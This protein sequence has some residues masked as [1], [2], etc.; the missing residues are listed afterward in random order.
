MKKCAM[1]FLVSPVLCG[2]VTTQLE[3]HTTNQVASLSDLRYQEVLDN[4]ALMASRNGALP[5]FALTGGGLTSVI[6]SVGIEPKTIWDP[7]GFL[8]QSLTVSG[9]YLPE[10]QWNIEPLVA[11]PQLQ[12]LKY[13]CVWA[14]YGQEA[15]DPL[16]ADY[17]R[18]SE[19]RDVFPAAKDPPALTQYHFDV[20]DRLS[21]LP[22]GWIHC[23]C[24]RDVDRCACYKSHCGDTYVWVNPDGLQAL[25]D[26]ALVVLDIATC[27]PNSLVPQSP[28]ATVEICEGPYNCSSQP[29]DCICSF[30]ELDS[31]GKPLNDPAHAGCAA[32]P[33]LVLTETWGVHQDATTGS[34]LVAGGGFAVCVPFVKSPPRTP[35]AAPTRRAVGKAFSSPSGTRYEPTEL[36]VAPP[37]P[38]S[39]P[40]FRTYGG[41]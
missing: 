3:S 12:A 23:G 32:D 10:L 19:R 39:L 34:Y 6:N 35:T 41:R 15:V 13:A 4:L 17:L 22:N 1:L 21:R 27:D 5:S 11:E 31:S 28:T 37:P 8:Q 7:H 2:C 24:R 38:V 30:A 14:L 25:S 16:G 36:Y 33:K 26:L 20:A 29:P 9:K 18:R 40:A